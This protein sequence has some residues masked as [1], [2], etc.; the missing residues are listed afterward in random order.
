MYSLIRKVLFLF[1]T[2]PIHYFSMNTLKLAKEIGFIKR[3]ITDKFSL[4]DPLLVTES[5]GLTFPNPVGLGAGFDKNARYLEELEMFLGFADRPEAVYDLC[6]EMW[7]NRFRAQAERAQSRDRVG[8]PEVRVHHSNQTLSRWI[9]HGAGC[10]DLHLAHH[11]F[12]DF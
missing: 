4:R 9:L 8:V 7:N 6:V 2:E 12:V 11:R 5:F 10:I 3:W 1:P